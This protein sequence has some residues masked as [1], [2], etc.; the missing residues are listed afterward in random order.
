MGKRELWLVVAFVVIGTVLYQATAPPSPEASGFSLRDMFRAARG[1]MGDRSA[2][3]SL[4]RHLTLNVPDGVDELALDDFRGR[5]EVVAGEGETVEVSIDLTLHGIDEDDLDLQEA[6]LRLHTETDGA[7]AVVK[8][9]HH[10][11]S[12]HPDM[13]MRVR[14]PRRLG[15]QLSGRGAAEITGVARAAFDDYRGDLVVEEVAGPITGSHREGRA[16]FGPGAVV[17]LETER[18][19]LRLV[20]PAAVTLRAEATDVEVMDAAGPVSIEQERCTLEVLGGDGPIEVEGEGGTIKL[21][22]VRSEVRIEA[23][24]LTVSMT[25]AAAVPVRLQIEADDVDVMLPNEGVEIAAMVD[26]GELRA[27]EGLTATT[28]DRVQRVTGA[29]N[30][31]GPRIDIDVTRGSLTIRRP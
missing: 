5:L 12:P 1:H 17:D 7:R 23:E 9:G 25:M 2:T 3:R 29:V 31:G 16:E 30:G 27:P 8:T 21:R 11:L 24:R 19:T 6:G 14:V 26:G 22:N 15:L 20:R 4:T 13:V 28:A 10:E 18:S